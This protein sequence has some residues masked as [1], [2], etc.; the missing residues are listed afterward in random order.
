[1]YKVGKDIPAGEYKVKLTGGMGYTEVTTSS[2]HQLDNI[3]SNDNLQ[4][5]SYIT[6]KDG[7]YLKMTGVEI[8]K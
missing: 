1:M 2:R 5:D 6:I 8:Q 3:V 4:A 7:Q